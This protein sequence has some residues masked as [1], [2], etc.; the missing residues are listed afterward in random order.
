MTLKVQL[1]SVI[2]Q[3][4]HV[5]PPH[6]QDITYMYW[7]NYCQSQMVIMKTGV[8]NLHKIVITTDHWPL[9]VLFILWLYSVLF[10]YLTLCMLYMA[11]LMY[12]CVNT[13]CQKQQVSKQVRFTACH[14]TGY[15]P[16]WQ[17]NSQNTH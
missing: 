11:I 9:F 15:S 12:T 6:P 7:C 4:I 2:T 17:K 5:D 1:S 13:G 3:T 8:H 16:N 10:H 14:N